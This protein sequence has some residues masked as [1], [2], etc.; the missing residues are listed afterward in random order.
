MERCDDD[1]AAT[2]LSIARFSLSRSAAYAA[3]LPPPFLDARGEM[4][5]VCVSSAPSLNPTLSVS[6]RR[7]D[8]G[9]RSP[10]RRPDVVAPVTCGAVPRSASGLRL[11]GCDALCLGDLADHFGDGG[12]NSAGDW[13]AELRNAN[14]GRGGGGTG[15]G[16]GVLACGG[17]VGDAAASVRAFFRARE[18]SA[19]A[20]ALALASAAAAFACSSLRWRMRC[21][22][23]WEA[24]M[25]CSVGGFWAVGLP[26]ARSAPGRGRFTWGD[27]ALGDLG[28]GLV[29]LLG[30]A[31]GTTGLGF[32]IGVVGMGTLTSA[33]HTVMPCAG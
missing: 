24:V 33:H 3:A 22:M 20:A 17:G 27:R 31:S 30:A 11:L 14:T 1:A 9:L 10:P 15:V 4:R 28:L 5:R 7:D 19:S 12:T 26:L 13:S 16:D 2:D 21:A 18:A 25:R 8:P 29:G 32:A 23:R 6:L